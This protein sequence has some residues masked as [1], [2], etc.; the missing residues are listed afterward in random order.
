MSGGSSVE[1]WMKKILYW[2]IEGQTHF[3][4][5]SRG[6]KTILALNKPK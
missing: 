5:Q 2:F 3:G 6:F 4:M 1:V